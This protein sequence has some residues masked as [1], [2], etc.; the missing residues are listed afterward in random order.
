ME[1]LQFI[2]RFCDSI[3]WLKSDVERSLAITIFFLYRKLFPSHKNDTYLE[4]PGGMHYI[5]S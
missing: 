2:S 4:H 1:M 5:D 3:L